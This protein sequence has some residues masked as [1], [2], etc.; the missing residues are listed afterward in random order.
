MPH[1]SP[2]A[3]ALAALLTLAAGP[4]LAQ[5]RT[6]PSGLSAAAASL[7][8]TAAPA[9]VEAYLPEISVQAPAEPVITGSVRPH[10]AGH[11]RSVH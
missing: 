11:G 1:P 3:A 8:Y 2:R 4:A 7:G 10:R 5:S 9:T 6:P